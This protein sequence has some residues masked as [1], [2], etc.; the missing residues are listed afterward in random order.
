MSSFA[1]DSGY[2]I[3]KRFDQHESL[4]YGVDWSFQHCQGGGDTLIASCS[5]YDCALHLWSG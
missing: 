2:E 4:A 5:F 1:D 3:T